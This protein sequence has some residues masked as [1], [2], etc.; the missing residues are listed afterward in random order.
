MDR[1]S[2]RMISV[3]HRAPKYW[4]IVMHEA[5]IRVFQQFRMKPR[6]M[7]QTNLMRAFEALV[8]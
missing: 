8:L 3:I 7:R 1:Q 2:E 6:M 4:K 5:G